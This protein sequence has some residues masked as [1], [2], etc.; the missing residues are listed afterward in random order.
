MK[1]LNITDADFEERFTRLVEARRESADDVGRDVT[2]I[3]NRVRARGDAAA[4]GSVP[5]LSA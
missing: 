2:E 3:L 5:D 4:A 1:R